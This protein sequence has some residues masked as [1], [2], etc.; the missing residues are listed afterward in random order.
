MGFFEREKTLL[1][2]RIHG[3]NLNEK[4]EEMISDRVVVV[5]YDSEV[6]GDLS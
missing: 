4:V 5:L 6:E 2:T 1:T 3:I